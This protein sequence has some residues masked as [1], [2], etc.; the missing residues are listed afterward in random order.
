M[1]CTLTKLITAG[2]PVLTHL[3]FRRFHSVALVSVQCLDLRYFSFHLLILHDLAL[4]NLF[5]F[6][7]IR[8]VDIINNLVIVVRSV[9]GTRRCQCRRGFLRIDLNVSGQKSSQTSLNCNCLWKTK[10]LI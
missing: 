6:V 5:Y 3:S 7:L 1:N 10:R 9:D 4:L 2:S 8:N